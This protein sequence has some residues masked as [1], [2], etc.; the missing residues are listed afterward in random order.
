MAYT[1]APQPALGV[2]TE[3]VCPM[4]VR[5]DYQEIS[6]SAEL[7]ITSETDL[8][9]GRGGTVP[10][11]IDKT[12]DFSADPI[13]VNAT[14]LFIQVVYRGQLGEE[15]DGIAV[16]NLD[17]QEPTFFAAWNNTDYYF[18]EIGNQWLAQN[19]MSFPARGVDGV[20]V[21]AVGQLVYRYIPENG[22]G[23]PFFVG[24]LTPG[25]VRLAFV[26]GKRSV[27]TTR[28][29]FR[30][31]PLMP[32]P[33]AQQR[34]P[35]APGQERQASREIF[36]A[37]DPLPA[38]S[39]CQFVAPVAGSTYWCFDPIQRRRGQ[40]FGDVA[41]PIY[42]TTGANGANG[43]DVDAPPNPHTPF[44]G[45]RV[46]DGGVNRFNEDAVLQTCPNPTSLSPAEIRSIELR[47]EA[48]S[49]GIDLAASSN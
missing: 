13:P 24:A 11:S 6:V 31:N 44:P 19:P 40:N 1:A 33:S 21:C 42:Y 35:A 46:R 28:Y 25:V 8:P 45:L 38:P 49:L 20:A 16:G 29:P 41:Q 30:V 2:I 37:N 4:G 43:P 48:W 27:L 12:F 10:A 14:D 7:P 3:P 36:T 39:V 34:L 9:G 22:P 47:E 32:A 23:L 18:S 26:F 17:V 5:T 15:T